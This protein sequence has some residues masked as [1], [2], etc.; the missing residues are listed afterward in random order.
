M[1][2]L[3][4]DECRNFVDRTS[5]FCSFR[6][7]ATIKFST[8]TKTK[9]TF[10]KSSI[11]ASPVELNFVSLKNRILS[12]INRDGVFLI[13]PKTNEDPN[14]KYQFVNLWIVS[15]RKRT[16]NFS[17]SDFERFPA[18]ET[19]RFFISDFPSR[20]SSLKSRVDT[21]TSRF[22]CFRTKPSGHSTRKKGRTSRVS[23]NF[24]NSS[25]K[26]RWRLTT[27]KS[28]SLILSETTISS[29]KT[30]S[31]WTIR[32]SFAHGNTSPNSW[33]PLTDLIKWIDFAFLIFSLVDRVR[34]FLLVPR[35]D[36][37]SAQKEIFV[38][39]RFSKIS[40]KQRWNV[41]FSFSEWIRR[42]S[43]KI[44]FF[45]KKFSTA[46]KVRREMFGREIKVRVGFLVEI[47]RKQSADC[48][49]RNTP[50]APIS[51]VCF[52]SIRKTLC[53]RCSPSIWSTSIS[54]TNE[55]RISIWRRTVFFF[56]SAFKE[57]IRP[58]ARRI[59]SFSSFD[60]DTKAKSRVFPVRKK[61]LDKFDSNLDKRNYFHVFSRRFGST[62]WV[63]RLSGKSA[64]SNIRLSRSSKRFFVFAKK[65]ELVEPTNFDE[66]SFLVETNPK[67]EKR[68]ARNWFPANPKKNRPNG[69]RF[70]LNW[71]ISWRISRRELTSWWK[72]LGLVERNF[73]AA[74][75]SI[76]FQKDEDFFFKESLEDLEKF[77]EKKIFV[78][79]VCFLRR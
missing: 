66:F 62:N 6:R 26:T 10:S 45:K 75:D 51:S 57:P 50:T 25:R 15:R 1:K 30:R 32:K 65:I 55:F 39:R 28:F 44:L 74:I 69:I 24:V 37:R 71:R 49:S 53:R 46:R 77:V 61:F 67:V 48:W 42:N 41:E 36:R 3:R 60:R 14:R 19:N 64:R 23:F 5:I 8:R 63:K 7:W 35:E 38:D 43:R 52:C 4:S 59:S 11:C 70:G 20:K 54:K 2:K 72:S 16:E 68:R 76:S 79:I 40:S 56:D 13:R 27:T 18:R 47:R 22:S 34:L 9:I 12:K 21:K 78:C 29:T 17:L 58:T 73:S 31:T 33:V